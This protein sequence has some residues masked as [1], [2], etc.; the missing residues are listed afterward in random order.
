MLSG[1]TDS[2]MRNTLIISFILS[3]AIP[4]KAAPEL[5]DSLPQKWEL[6]PQYMQTTPDNDR[7]W[8]SFHDS[9]L[10]TLINH[11]VDNNYNVLEAM[12]RIELARL[13]QRQTESGYYPTINANAGWQRDHSAGAITPGG[14]SM[15]TDYFSLGLSMNW[16]AD[17]FGRIREQVKADKAS[18]RATLADYDA[19]LVSLCSSLAKA[20][21]QLRVAQAQY[22]VAEENIAAQEELLKLATARYEA[23]LVPQL[24]VVQARM[25]VTDTR[26]TLPQLKNLIASSVYQVSLLAGEYPD[27]LHDILNKGILPDAPAPVPVGLPQSLLRRRPDIVAAEQQLARYAALIGVAKKEFLPVLSLSASVGTEAHRAGDLF[28]SQSLA[29]SVMPTLSWTIFDG[30]ARNA[31]VAEAKAQ[32][33]TAIDSYNLTVMTAVSEV[34]KAISEYNSLNDQ[35][36]LSE[37]LVKDGKKALELQVDRYRQGLVDFSDIAQTLLSLLGYENSLISIRGNSLASLVTLYTALGGG[38]EVTE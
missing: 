21:F 16:E 33:L 11:A 15:N 10:L 35:L 3:L 4:V 25:V 2:S 9:T 6:E 22:K 1:T 5:L 26:N 38:Y 37:M 19:T 13:A 24:D 30:F 12:H 32:M 8:V 28:G 34:N 18:Y 29:Y 17:V 20:Y 14:R 31:R 23:G 27:K 7:W 36:V